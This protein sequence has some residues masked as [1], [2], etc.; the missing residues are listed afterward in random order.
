MAEIR[1]DADKAERMIAQMI[2]DDGGLLSFRFH[3]D[4]KALKLFR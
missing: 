2:R 3:H 1:I 4:L